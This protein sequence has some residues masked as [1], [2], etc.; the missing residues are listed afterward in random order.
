MPTHH[1]PLVRLSDNR[2]VTTSNA[3]S[4][5]FY[6]KHENI[7]CAIDNLT[8]SE[9]FAQNNYVFCPN[10]G[11]QY[12]EPVYEIT[13]SGFVFLCI[14]FIEKGDAERVETYITAFNQ[15]EQQLHVVKQEFPS[16][17]HACSYVVSGIEYMSLQDKYIALLEQQ[18]LMRQPK[19]YQKTIRPPVQPRSDLRIR[20]K[21]RPEQRVEIVRLAKQGYCKKDMAKH[22]GVSRTTIYAV[23]NRVNETGGE[24]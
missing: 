7:L 13:F 5:Y 22:Y 20:G 14:D 16:S 10:V 11:G 23:I 8:C 4:Q 24:L 19:E 15:L 17:D 2:L 6:K 3:V 21:L 1:I 18:N 12:Q 9:E